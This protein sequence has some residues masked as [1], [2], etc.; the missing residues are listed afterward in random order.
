[1]LAPLQAVT[2][3]IRAALGD[4]PLY[5]SAS[6]LNRDDPDPSYALLVPISQPQDPNQFDAVL[7]AGLNVWGP[8][9]RVSGIA[10]SLEWLD[11]HHVGVYENLQNIRYAR[12]GRTMFKEPET[13]MPDGATELWNLSET[14]RIIYAHF[15]PEVVP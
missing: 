12:Q 6:R 15:A 14:Y 9:W 13:S 11:G 1:M 7:I 8:L 5:L 2:P 10:E 3:D 4:V